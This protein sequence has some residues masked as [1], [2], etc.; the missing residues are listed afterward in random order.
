MHTGIADC[1]VFAPTRF[2]RIARRGDGWWVVE[3]SDE[4]SVYNFVDFL[5][6]YASWASWSIFL[7][8]LVADAVGPSGVF[9]DKCIT[10]IMPRVS[11]KDYYTPEFYKTMIEFDEYVVTEG[12]CQ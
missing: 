4:Y 10:L 3:Q 12:V 6:N 9:G 11:Y 2:V 8:K 5:I 1:V 7:N